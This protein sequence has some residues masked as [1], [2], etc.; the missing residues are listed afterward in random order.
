MPPRKRPLSE[1]EHVVALPTHRQSKPKRP[2]INKSKKPSHAARVSTPSAAQAASGSS[3]AHIDATSISSDSDSGPPQS[4]RCTAPVFSFK[5]SATIS[6]P[7]A[8]STAG[9]RRGSSI[10]DPISISSDSEGDVQAVPIVDAAPIAAQKLPSAL[11][12]ASRPKPSPVRNLQSRTPGN[13]SQLHTPG[14][15]S[16]IRTQS[17]PS[18]GGSMAA[19]QSA[20]YAIAFF[21]YSFLVH[22][23]Y[24][25]TFYISRRAGPH[26]PNSISVALRHL[27]HQFC[28]LFADAMVDLRMLSRSVDELHEHSQRPSEPCPSSSARPRRSS[29]AAQT[30]SAP[31][32]CSSAP[33]QHS[34]EAPQP[35]SVH[36]QSSSEAAQS[37]H[38]PPAPPAFVSL[39]YRRSDYINDGRFP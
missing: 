37:N 31:T 9:A 12:A 38:S 5:P 18:V 30:S 27:E 7:T 29:D 35:S 4:P 36:T 8:T 2:K 13:P 32:Q 22:V 33:T 14:P 26:T 15:S 17:L 10:Q 21:F 34:S 6:A 1:D 19:S 25:S 23:A 20:R 39:E 16:I 24:L 11:T 28:S 3:A